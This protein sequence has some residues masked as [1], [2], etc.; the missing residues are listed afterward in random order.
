MN[1]FTA[2][3]NFLFKCLCIITLNS[4]C[5]NVRQVPQQTNMVDAA[6]TGETLNLTLIKIFSDNDSSSV[7]R[8]RQPDSALIITSPAQHLKS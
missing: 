8:L 1:Y 2:T 7:F 4:C 5:A 3:S 6:R